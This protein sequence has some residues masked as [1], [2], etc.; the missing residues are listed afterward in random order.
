MKP[1][2]W[3][4]LGILALLVVGGVGGWF[5]LRQQFYVLL[6]HRGQGNWASTRMAKL[7]NVDFA[8]L[9]RELG[10]D[11]WFVRCSVLRTL[12]KMD[13]KERIFPILEKHLLRE[14]E[15]YC[16]LELAAGLIRFKEFDRAKAVLESL[17]DDPKVGDSARE[18]LKQWSQPAGQ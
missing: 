13:D 15:S 3:I 9:E 1:R 11:K 8:L 2:H 14:K 5:V 4:I 6:M 16:L 7:P 18:L 12:R 10:S 17:V